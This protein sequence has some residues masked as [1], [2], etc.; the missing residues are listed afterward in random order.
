MNIDPYKTCTDEELWNALY[1]SKL[2]YFVKSLP[3][4]FDYE[5]LENGDNFSSGQRQLLCLAR[6]LVRKSKLVLL[7][8]AT[9][10]VDY[11]T[12]SLIQKTIDTE[13]GKVIGDRG[14]RTTTVLTIAHRLST[15]LNS[16]KILVMDAGVVKEFGTPQDLLSNP[17][18]LFYQLFQAESQEKS[19]YSK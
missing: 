13:F 14:E 3:G 8:E 11:V 9:S 19:A 18:S 10:S 6:A 12:D 15:V 5:I 1:N 2:F 16:D 17:E 4:Q 7:D